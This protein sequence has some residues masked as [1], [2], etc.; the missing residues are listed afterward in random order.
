[1]VGLLPTRQWVK[2]CHLVSIS[3]DTE[4]PQTHGPNK[5]QDTRDKAKQ[6]TADSTV[7]PNLTYLLKIGD[8]FCCH[9][10]KKK[11]SSDFLHASAALKK[12][13]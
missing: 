8:F 12:I 6:N 4:A 9:I 3:S 5:A 2:H 1:M 11:M 10:T 13:I 7:A